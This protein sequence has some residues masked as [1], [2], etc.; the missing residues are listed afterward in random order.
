MLRHYDFQT[1]QDLFL[2]CH[3]KEQDPKII[4]FVF[5]KLV[6]NFCELP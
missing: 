5:P 3:R 6:A 4:M 2:M 1:D